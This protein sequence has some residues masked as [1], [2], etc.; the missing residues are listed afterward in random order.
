MP[1]SH[2]HQ[3][4]CVPLRPSTTRVTSRRLLGS[5]VFQ[6]SRAE[7]P[8][9]RNR[10]TAF[11]S[12]LGRVLPSQTRTIC[13]P[14]VA[15]IEDQGAVRLIGSGQRVP[16]VRRRLGPAMVAD[17]GDPVPE[18]FV[19]HRLVGAAR[20]RVIIADERHVPG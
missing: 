18:L 20:L 10:W 7:L 8:H 5:A 11:A 16:R 2:S 12:P 15:H 13:A 19:D 4:L 6:I 17:I 1:V 14:R 3:L 9:G